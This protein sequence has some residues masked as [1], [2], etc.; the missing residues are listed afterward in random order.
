MIKETNANILILEREEDSLKLLEHHLLGA[1]Y[2]TITTSLADQALTLIANND[3]DMIVVGISILGECEEAF[4]QELKFS[5]I[6][7]SI[8]VVIFG[9]ADDENEIITALALGADELI[10]KPYIVSVMLN[11]VYNMLRLSE[12]NPISYQPAGEKISTVGIPL[13]ESYKSASNTHDEAKDEERFPGIDYNTGVHNVL[14]DDDLFVE[15]L[16]MFYEDHAQDKDKIKQAIIANDHAASKS[17]VHTLKGVAGSI[18]AH[19]LFNATKALDT[20][21][22]LNQEDMYQSLFSPVYDELVRVI[23]GLEINIIN[24]K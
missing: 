23:S 20:A 11:R 22:N 1:G 21:L 8:P 7:A 10:E 4:I 6:M 19:D 14:G 12:R 5:P 17:L 15:I 9:S 16:T 13:E 3:V 18:G 2:K 24:K